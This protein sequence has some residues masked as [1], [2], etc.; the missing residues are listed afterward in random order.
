REDRAELVLSAYRLMWLLMRR[1]LFI[2]Q[3]R[4]VAYYETIWSWS[5]YICDARI[6]LWGGT[7]SFSVQEHHRGLMKSDIA[8][9]DGTRLLDTNVDEL[10]AYFVARYG[11]EVPELLEERIAVI[12]G[13]HSATYLVTLGEWHT[14]SATAG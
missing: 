12:N 13:G 4:G 8:G 1:G 3:P 2:A 9:M 11:V 14:I 7:D 10:V 6:V 5:Y